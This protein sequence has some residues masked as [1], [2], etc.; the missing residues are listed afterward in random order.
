MRTLRLAGTELRRFTIGRMPKLALVAVVLLPL[1][2]G[3]LYL[4]AFWDPYGRL[5]NAPAALVVADRGETVDGKHTNAG[6]DLAKKLAASK[7]AF[8]WHVTTADDASKGV[9]DGRYYLSLTI[10]ADFSAQLA[11]PSGDHPRQAQL[12]VTTNDANNYLAGTIGRTVFS[13]VRAAVAAQAGT[14]Y[15]D[16]M[17]IGFTELHAS[18]LQAASGSNQLATGADQL[19]TGLGTLSTGAGKLRSGTGQLSSGLDQLDTST[20]G[21]P[22]ATQKLAAGSAKVAAGD[23]QIATL[24]NQANTALGNAVGKLKTDRA[25]VAQ[26]LRQDG[27]T[28]AQITEILA[29]YDKATGRLSTASTV[30]AG[31]AAQLNQ[32][33][34]GA[35]QVAAGNAKLAAAAPALHNGIHKAATGAAQLDSGAGRLSG[36]LQQAQSGA[37]KLA[38]GAH[39]LSGKLSTGA[40]QIPHP[41]ASTRDK[42]AGAMGD[43]VAVHTVADN[44]VPNYGTGFAPYFLPLALLG[45]RGRALHA[46]APTLRTRVGRPCTSSVHGTCRVAAGGRHR[47]PAGPPA[48]RGRRV[49]A[50]AADRQSAGHGGL[51]RVDCPGVHGTGPDVPGVLRYARPAARAGGADGAAG[52]RGRHV[53]LGDHPAGAAVPASAAADVVRRGRLAPPDRRRRRRDRPARCVGIAGIRRGRSGDHDIR[54][55]AQAHLVTEPIAS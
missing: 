19:T 9:A 47:R 42:Q 13:E 3:A 44:K 30:V 2:Y 49:R 14:K 52:Q 43:P 28:D 15:A 40:G 46:A 34:A 37:A 23:K 5:P 17:L 6:Q 11:S 55:L 1:L 21:L 51:P 7:A 24:G 36:G 29:A 26:R 22:S 4:Y 25:A 8:G 20:A 54:G 16:T 10:P 41:D 35:D 12:Q 31:K 39:T 45:R 32:L 53:P 33:S 18:T 38:G 27:L 48:D 50:R